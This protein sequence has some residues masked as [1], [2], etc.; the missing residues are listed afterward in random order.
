M[1]SEMEGH[2]HNKSCTCGPL[3]WRCCWDL[4]L[5]LQI[6]RQA[7]WSLRW[8]WGKGLGHGVRHTQ[9][10]QPTAPVVIH[11]LLILKKRESQ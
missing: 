5:Y 1:A 6:Q 7:K 2:F 9:G 4:L 10:L 11:P 8:G 3:A